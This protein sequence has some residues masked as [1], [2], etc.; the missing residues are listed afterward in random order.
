MSL[1]RLSPSPRAYRELK[2]VLEVEVE[3]VFE[4]LGLLVALLEEGGP[5]GLQQV[6]LRVGVTR[7][8]RVPLRQPL[9]THKRT[10]N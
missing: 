10:S 4:G 2:L 1:Y 7:P 9:S 3:H 6:H 5:V 8:H